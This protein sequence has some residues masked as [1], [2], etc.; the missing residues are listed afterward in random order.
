[1]AIARPNCYAFKAGLPDFPRY[2]IPKWG[3]YTK[4]QRNILKGHKI[5][6][7]FSIAM[8]SQSI[9]NGDFGYENI[10]SGNP[11]SGRIYVVC[12]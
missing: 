8:H 11:G 1:L 7:T 4:S 10:P 9:S 12:S 2:N 5:P 3:K 6:P